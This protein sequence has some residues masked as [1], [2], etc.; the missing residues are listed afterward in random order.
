SD[1]QEI[2][3]RLNSVLEAA[4]KTILNLASATDAAEKA[5]KEGREEDL[6][7]Y[8]DQAASYQ[9]QVD[10]YAVETVRLL[11]ELKKVFPDEEADRALQIA[12]KLLKTVQEASKTLDTAVAAAANGDEETFAKAFNQFVSLGNQADTLFT[13][14]QRT[15]TNLNKK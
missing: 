4:W 14:L 13:Q 11:A 12:E 2:L 6:A 1:A 5:Y 8:L 7:T 15:L 9:S 10:Q 3:S